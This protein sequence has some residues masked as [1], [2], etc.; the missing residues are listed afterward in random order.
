M[1]VANYVD[2]DECMRHEVNHV[3]RTLAQ[4]WWC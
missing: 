4:K 2:S 1:R 3:S